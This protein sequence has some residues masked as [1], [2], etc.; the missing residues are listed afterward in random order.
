MKAQLV[1]P[2]RDTLEA[3]GLGKLGEAEA[4]A[5][6]QHLAEC[7][8]CCDSLLGMQDDTFIEL[9]R[10]A[11]T[12]SAP[13]SETPNDAAESATRTALPSAPPAEG[14]PRAPQVVSRPPELEHHPRYRV[15]ELLGRGGM[16]EVYKA[17]HR[18]MHRPVA[19][20]V[21]H[22]RLMKDAHAVERFRREVQAAARLSHPNIVAAYDAEQAGDLHFLAMEFVEGIDLG[23]LVQQRG[24]LP[25]TE[26][27]EYTRQAADALQHAH[28]RNM[29][30][31]DIK[32][33]NL[34]LAG[35]RNARD[36]QQAS[37]TG[38][39][40]QTPD[41]GPLTPTIKVLDFGLARF[42][43]DVADE[44][45]VDEEFVAEGPSRL[46]LHGATMGTPDYIAPEQSHSAREA[47]I[48]SD[49]YSLGCTLYFLLT[50]RP[51]FAGGSALEKLRAHAKSVPQPVREYRSDIPPGLEEVLARM[52]AKD[53]QDRFATPAAVAAALA[54]FVRVQ[55]PS[56]TAV[57]PPPQPVLAAPSSCGKWRW[58]ILTVLAGALAI[59]LGVIFT[60]KLGGT[61]IRFEVEDPTLAVHFR[62][63]EITVNNDGQTLRITPGQPQSFTIHHNGVEA[64]TTAFT[65]RKGQDVVLTVSVDES[66]QVNVGSS[67][68][69][70]ALARQPKRDLEQ[71]AP[72]S[73]K[74]EPEQDPSILKPLLT[75]DGERVASARDIQ[76]MAISADRKQLVTTHL[77][78]SI[79]L[80]DIEKGSGRAS[81]S[82]KSVTVWSNSSL[83]VSP[84]GRLATL[85]GKT[86]DQVSVA[87]TVYLFDFSAGR[88]V[89]RL[90]ELNGF[91]RS[92]AFSPDGRTLLI[93][94][95]LGYRESS[96]KSEETK[97]ERLIGLGR[98][99]RWWNVETA[100]ES[101]T[102]ELPELLI[103]TAEEDEHLSL[104]DVA[105]SH[106]GKFLAAVAFAAQ[107]GNQNGVSR[108]AREGAFV[109]DAATGRI[110]HQL[111]KTATPP[112]E[113]AFTP[114]N[115]FLVT[116]HQGGPLAESALNVWDAATGSLVRTIPGFHESTSHLD[117]S[118]DGRLVGTIGGHGMIR[119]WSLVEG[120]HVA[121]LAEEPPE[122][123]DDHFSQHAG[124]RERALYFLA[125]SRSFVTGGD[126]GVR[127]W[128][129]PREPG[130]A[131][132]VMPA[133]APEPQ[134][135]QIAQP[136]ALSPIAV[137]QGEHQGA[138][139]P[140]LA[141]HAAS[142]GDVVATSHPAGVIALWDAKTKREV[143]SWKAPGELHRALAISP[144]GRFIATG[145]KDRDGVQIWSSEGQR[146]H[147]LK[148]DGRIL[149]LKFSAQGDVLVAG[150]SQGVAVDG[151][152]ET[153]VGV[154]SPIRVWDVKTGEERQP[155]T[156]P[157]YLA[158]AREDKGSVDISRL[159]IS[160]DG[161]LLFVSRA[162]AYHQDGRNSGGGADGAWNLNTGEWAQPR[163]VTDLGD[164]MTF[165]PDGRFITASGFSDSE[166]YRL[167]VWDYA[168]GT[169]IFKLKGHQT[170][171][172]DL[173]VSPDGR[174]L[175]SLDNFGMFFVW[176][177][178]SGR[179][180]ARRDS[181]PGPAPDPTTWR[182]IGFLSDN[183]SFVT[184][185]EQ[186][187]T[188]WRLPDSLAS[189]PK[190]DVKFGKP[191]R[192]G[193]ES[194]AVS[195]FAISADRQWAFFGRERKEQFAHGEVTMWSLANYGRKFVRWS[196]G[197][198]APWV[199]TTSADG[200]LIAIGELAQGSFELWNAQTM[201][202]E[203]MLPG[204]DAHLRSL[205]FSPDGRWIVSGAMQRER[206][207][208]DKKPVAHDQPVRFWDVASREERFWKMPEVLKS[209][210]HGGRVDVDA[211]RFSPSGRWLVAVG[212]VMH[213]GHNNTLVRIEDFGVVWDVQTGEVVRRLDAVKTHATAMAFSPDEKVLVT[214]HAGGNEESCVVRVWDFATGR[215]LRAMAG[216][217]NPVW[218]VDV[219]PDGQL[220]ASVDARG[221]LRLWRLSDGAA[222]DAAPPDAADPDAWR[223]R[224]GV[225]FTA[226]GKSLITAGSD[227][228]KVWPM[229]V[230]PTPAGS[231]SAQA[232]ETPE[233]ETPELDEIVRLAKAE[234]ERTRTR[235]TVGI[236]SSVD[237][238]RAEVKLVEAQIRR[239]AARHDLQEQRDLLTQL[240]A[241][242]QRE[243]ELL[244]TLHK[245][246]TVTESAVSEKQSQLLEIQARL[247]SI[248]KAVDR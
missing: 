78:A 235:H 38:Q 163:I 7:P 44:E 119:V 23:Q 168:T 86:P 245:L 117:I 248:P 14:S 200:K 87:K 169:M 208:D 52:M 215:V 187:V 196:A 121:S 71:I 123:I 113:I 92:M 104:G 25:V 64:Q 11:E 116:G 158:P 241:L 194:K 159:A 209:A 59:C 105:F 49:I 129:A 180:V 156:I 139:H 24:P 1:H 125:D 63:N 223:P 161:Q 238:I 236:S 147:D 135:A 53:P 178:Q 199:M 164:V 204:H 141:M 91:P 157:P 170:A 108:P 82:T 61:T 221:A 237:L 4:A 56:P 79:A 165:A 191:S 31:R 43:T 67:D 42:A 12:P 152:R 89:R 145:D 166:P 72:P 122:I 206:K 8:S 174:W 177:L 51:P 148:H 93:G 224:V 76:A 128:R 28:S 198:A 219:S 203:A 109:W 138:A 216:H 103:A 30:H 98:G 226:D 183:R 182:S 230:A 218:S 39:G 26:A 133:P 244:T 153:V 132:A 149:A 114:D 242:H 239:A 13:R 175:V 16:G 207:D 102:L 69:K 62:E 6:E 127:L 160:P 112:T 118:P 84:D 18:L 65:L 15:L 246:G 144:D 3:F 32:P 167:R 173:S 37:S 68:P 210:T 143:R 66:G 9:V 225:A 74:G 77:R 99:L 190:P 234:L 81:W 176:D 45:T 106:D 107:H 73:A 27:C 197:G 80:W 58:R 162:R 40:K 240:V 146:L 33:Q 5:V 110:V 201:R 50:G 96:A 243:L 193:Q 154:D 47:D 2:Q 97:R 120:K 101:E 150:A 188:L 34:M 222:L 70:V 124:P 111:A 171:I 181:E 151:E 29:V 10:Q 137:L 186:G 41:S 85:I 213:F 205:A 202:Q 95:S 228:V 19:I 214:G 231:E 192:F 195:G 134:A 247:R 46:T 88:V 55:T 35:V 100:R 217:E 22:R 83:A 232:P 211:V 115:R 189:S 227:G 90:G 75:F 172:V 57:K 179:E 142:R 233:P 60:V 36:P 131:K 155:F 184:N 140:I 94:E 212:D 185:E 229:Q 136:A 220:I 17:E 126:E 48:R 130:A 21:I 20:K 54:P